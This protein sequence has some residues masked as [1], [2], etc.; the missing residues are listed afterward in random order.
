MARADRVWAM[1]SAVRPP[2]PRPKGKTL[3]VHP[4]VQ[5]L[6]DGM[7]QAGGPPLDELSPAEAREV[8]RG[9]IALDQPEEVTRVDDRLIPGDGNDVPGARVHARRRRGRQRPAAASGS[10]AA[11]G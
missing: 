5:L 3:P 4:Q 6:L 9:L 8:F 2:G 7:A 1:M 10:T 11:A